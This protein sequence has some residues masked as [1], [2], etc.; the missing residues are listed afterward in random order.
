M[1]KINKNAKDAIEE[2]K[3]EPRPGVKHLFVLMDESGSMRGLEEHVVTGCN[4]FIHNFA[5]DP[6]ARVWLAWFDRSP[7]EQRTRVKLHGVPAP[8]ATPLTPGDY[9]P[10][11]RTPLNDAI[12]D[13]VGLLD[14]VAGPDEVVFLAIITD[15]MENASETSTETIKQLLVAREAAGWGIVFVGANQD[16]A[17]TAAARGMHKPSRS[18][19]FRADPA[20]VREA[21][22]EV[23]GMAR[24]RS[25][26]AAGV[27]GLEAF[28]R[29]VE[30]SSDESGRR[31]S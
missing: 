24:S 5:D 18:R 31:R 8:E 15:G 28:D 25:Q 14:K 6:G 29:E 16:T 1:P 10:R 27:E 22:R 23:S 4:E 13:A 12:A 3:T 11:G 7:G 2:F 19:D 26:Y 17:H 30:G 21:M 9:N 20:G